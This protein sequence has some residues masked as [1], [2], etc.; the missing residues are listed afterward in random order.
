MKQ[1]L[2]ALLFC[3]YFLSISL[4]ANISNSYYKTHFIYTITK[5]KTT[6]VVKAAASSGTYGFNAGLQIDVDAI[7]TELAKYEE[8]SIG[9]K[10]SANNVNINAGNTATVQGS[11]V[12]AQEAI[13][14]DANELNIQA[15]KDTNN[16]D[17]NTDHAHLSI[18]IDSGGFGMS[19]SA[20]K[21]INSDRQAKYTNSSFS[22]NNIN[23]NVK[24]TTNIVGANIAA[25]DELNLKTK[26]LN[27]E[28][29]QDTEKSK[30][31]SIGASM[32][33][34]GGAVSSVGANASKA[35]S[36]SKE[37]VLTT[38]TGFKRSFKMG[39]LF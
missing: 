20:D 4:H 25:N 39:I 7:D 9:S 32:G 34:G 29:V 22:A 35:N 30:S 6:Q 26:N 16:Q 28:S 24:E 36:K 38:L 33:V 3:S 37:T 11:S 17:S 8:H 5:I 13:N 15:S 31:F 18:T 2:T 14:V 21:T 27:V 10:L 12:D 23:L 19:A 1:T